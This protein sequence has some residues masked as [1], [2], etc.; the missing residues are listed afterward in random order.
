MTLADLTYKKAEQED[1]DCVRACIIAAYEKYIPRIGQEPGPMH[2][3]YID[4]INRGVVHLFLKNNSVVA[5]IVMFPKDNS[6][7]VDNIAIDPKVQG[8]GILMNILA[9]I[10]RVAIQSK[11]GEIR[12]YTNTAMTENISLYESLG[13]TLVDERVELGYSRVYM[14]YELSPS[15]AIEL[16]QNVAKIER[17]YRYRYNRKKKEAG[18]HL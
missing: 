11:L 4:L 3:D 2:A 16:P 14:R 5:V 9:L 7:D 6:L 12:F 8:R 17:K 10:E 1:L 15:L 13:A 18:P